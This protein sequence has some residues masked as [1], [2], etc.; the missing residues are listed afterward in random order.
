MIIH[1]TLKSRSGFSIAVNACV[2]SEYFK[3][4][5]E[6]KAR[7]FLRPA[8]IDKANILARK[9]YLSKQTRQNIFQ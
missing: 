3:L 2:K 7:S 6:N 4:A 1:Q 8:S 5:K 9:D